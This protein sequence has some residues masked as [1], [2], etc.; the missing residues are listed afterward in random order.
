ML[1]WLIFILTFAVFFATH[2][3]PTRPAIKQRITLTIGPADFTC[4]YSLLSLAMLGLL[5]WAAGRAA[6]IHL[7]SPAVWHKYLALGGMFAVCMLLV[8]SIARPNPFSFGGARNDDYDPR[9]PGLV[10]WIRHP[11]LIALAIWSGLH[12]PPNGDLAHVLLFAVFLG[13]ALLGQHIVDRRKRRQMGQQEW[14]LLLSRTKSAPVWQTP[15]SLPA[16]GIRVLLGVLIWGALLAA[17]PI[18]IGVSPLP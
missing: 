12:I 6:F 10:R 4:C 13:F 15:Q 11:L 5:I 8:F 16:I 1:S 9:R 3:I 7:W 18:V 17:H 2:A 14:R